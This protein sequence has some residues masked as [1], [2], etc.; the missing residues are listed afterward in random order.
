[1]ASKRRFVDTPYLLHNM[2]R[3]VV[4]VGVWKNGIELP[5]GGL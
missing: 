2:Q 5:G 3:P 4:V 1:M